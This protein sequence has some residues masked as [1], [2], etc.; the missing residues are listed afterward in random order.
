MIAAIE[1]ANALLAAMSGVVAKTDQRVLG[2]GGVVEGTQR[3]VDQANA[4]LGELRESLKRVD[5]ILAD[6]QS[7]T[8]N[9]KAATQDLGALRAEVDAS[10]RKVTGLIDESTANGPSSATPKFAC[11]ETVLLAAAAAATARL[12]GERGP[13]DAV[14]PAALLRRR[15]RHCGGRVQGGAQRA[16]AYRPRRPRRARRARAAS[17]QLNQ[18]QGTLP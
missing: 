7:V 10:L 12:A 5:K 15:Y 3:A 6:A 9:A 1:R 8:G 17:T 13:S 18:E 16:R 4:I 11:L 2:P 14:V